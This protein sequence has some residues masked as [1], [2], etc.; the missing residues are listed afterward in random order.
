MMNEPLTRIVAVENVWASY[1]Y[2]PTGQLL[3]EMDRGLLQQGPSHHALGQL[4][5]H[6]AGLGGELFETT[7]FYSQ[8]ILMVRLLGERVLVILADPSAN[9]PL[10]RLTLDVVLHEWRQQGLDH[11]FPM[12]C[13]RPSG[14]TGWRRVFGKGPHKG[15]APGGG[16]S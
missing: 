8:G 16:K 1:V 5:R 13:R 6:M 15:N 3:A 10:I 4:A 7:L 14:K 2:G 9:L 11:L 12:A